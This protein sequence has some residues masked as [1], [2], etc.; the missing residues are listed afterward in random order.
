MLLGYAQQVTLSNVGITNLRAQNELAYF[1]DDWKVSPRLT[2][3]LGVR[4]ELYLPIWEVDNLYGNFLTDRSDRD[5]GKLVYAGLNGRSRSLMG[6]D[7]NNFAPRLGF[8]YRVP[9]TGDLTI[10]GGYGMFYGNPDEQTGVGNMMTNNPPFVGAG[11]VTL[12]GDRNFP[13]TSFNLSG[14]L[15]AT[16]PRIP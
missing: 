13:A 16:P 11:G 14:R 15:P 2:L 6:A 4:Y 1:Q 12:I 9:H 7:K 5:F 10:R 3:N 8:A